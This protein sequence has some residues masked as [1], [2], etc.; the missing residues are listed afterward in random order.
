MI[1]LTTLSQAVVPN[2][3]SVSRG[4]LSCGSRDWCDVGETLDGLSSLEGD[5]MR[6][7]RPI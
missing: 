7:N 1:G 2:F 6:R 5:Q 4:R 3:S